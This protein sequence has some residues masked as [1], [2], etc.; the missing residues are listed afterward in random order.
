MRPR[1][2]HLR[3]D[4]RTDSKPGHCLSHHGVTDACPV[5]PSFVVTLRGT[6]GAEPPSYHQ[7]YRGAY[8]WSDIEPDNGWTHRDSNE[9][10][11]INS[12]GPSAN[13]AADF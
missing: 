7:P 8:S 3:A 10:G 2:G 1:S 9:R 12:D 11:H 6:F 5:G 4:S 13:T